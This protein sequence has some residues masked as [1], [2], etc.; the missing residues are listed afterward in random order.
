MPTNLATP[1]VP[2]WGPLA[3]RYEPRQPR[4]I[5]SL[6][7]GGIRGILTLEILLE[8]ERQLRDNL[9]A[10]DR[11]VLSDFFDYI[12]KQ[13]DRMIVCVQGWQ[14]PRRKYCFLCVPSLP[15]GLTILPDKSKL[16]Q[17]FPSV[18]ACVRTDVPA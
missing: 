10:G 13:G 7:G 9:G 5:L 6:D 12:E 4:K 14:S 2:D 3:A 17:N 11:F 16:D 1:T 15:G 8:M 18:G